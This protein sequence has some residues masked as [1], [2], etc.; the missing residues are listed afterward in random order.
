MTS[1]IKPSER[2]SE[3]NQLS[4]EQQEFFKDVSKEV[5]D[6]NIG[7]CS[8]YPGGIDTNFRA[9]PNHNYLRPESVAKMIKA[10]IECDEGCVHDIV[11]R[12]FIENNIA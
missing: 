2:D 10:C 7:V 6:E 8:V 5:K 4:Q 12:P 3:G 1:E 9:I 11:M